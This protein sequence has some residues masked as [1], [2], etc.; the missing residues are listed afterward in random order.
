MKLS[1][2]YYGDPVLRKKA[3][4]V[5][6]I[7]P[8]IHQLVQGMKETMEAHKG[9]GLAAPQV[10]HSLALFVA[11]IPEDEND[12]TVLG[13]FRVFINPKIVGYSEEKWAC[14]EGCLSIPGLKESVER[15]LKVTIQA[16][17]LN[18]QTFVEEFVGFPAHVI[19]H[20]N[21]HLNGVFF[22]DRLPSQRKK[23]IEGYLKEVKRKFYSKI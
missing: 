6:E 3:A 20:E 5:E 22:I 21:D 4:P 12:R 14:Q 9:C 15:P 10:H 7:T 2:A 18:H 1:L 23:A 11:T 16:T 13:P 8:F 19:M 17:D